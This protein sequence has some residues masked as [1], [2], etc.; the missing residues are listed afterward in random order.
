MAIRPHIVA[1]VL[2]LWVLG[3]ERT[4]FNRIGAAREKQT[5]YSAQCGFAPL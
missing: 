2:T 4:N 1:K 5:Y 3:M